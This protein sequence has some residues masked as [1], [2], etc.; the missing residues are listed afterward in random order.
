M[1]ADLGI[2]VLEEV[3]LKNKEHLK[4]VKDM[5]DETRKNLIEETGRA[6]KRMSIL[7]GKGNMFNEIV[8]CSTT[9]KYIK[10][11]LDNADTNQVK[12]KGKIGRLEC[13][14]IEV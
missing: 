13:L 7:V 1:A 12:Q 6:S 8:I 11:L 10:K 3:N 5:F 9:K 14:K 4:K 2:P